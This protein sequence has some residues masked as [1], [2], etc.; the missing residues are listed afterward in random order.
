MAS[1]PKFQSNV[2]QQLSH[3]SNST[4]SN[5]IRDYVEKFDFYKW[6]SLYC[7]NVCF[8]I[9]I[10]RM[11]RHKFDVDQRKLDLMTEEF[12]GPNTFKL[13]RKLTEKL[14][15]I[16]TLWIDLDNFYK[17]PGV[18]P[19]LFKF[20]NLKILRIHTTQNTLI[21]VNI[22][23]P[24]FLRKLT[25]LEIFIDN[26]SVYPNQVVI[27]EFFINGMPNLKV[28][29]F[30]NIFLTPFTVHKL[31]DLK[32][33]TLKLFDV[34]TDINLSDLF[35]QKSIK[36]ISLIYEEIQNDLFYNT[37]LYALFNT[38]LPGNDNIEE[39]SFSITTFSLK[40]IDFGN[41]LN[42]KRLKRLTFFVSITNY[43]FFL[44]LSKMLSIIPYIP[45]DCQIKFFLRYLFVSEENTSDNKSLCEL[46]KIEAQT[47]ERNHKN[48][49]FSRTI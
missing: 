22:D 12:D 15:S 40:E 49:K 38:F 30:Q 47:L 1:T 20:L 11:R 24:L 35:S 4:Q 36:I 33:N 7:V 19:E 5:N 42:L 25:H 37:I 23:S 44:A 26:T 18:L 14:S 34:H 16:E 39:I 21:D 46:I 10:N 45:K 41:I 8:A 17:N 31:I 43:N 6:L 27:P 13:L 9:R 28:C 29:I 48:F 32:I 3:R 2:N